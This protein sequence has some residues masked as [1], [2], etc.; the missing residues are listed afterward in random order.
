LPIADAAARREITGRVRPELSPDGRWVAYTVTDPRRLRTYGALGRDYTLVTETGAA[1]LVA[2]TDVWVANTTTGDARSVTGGVGGNW[3]AAW[4]PDGRSLAFY[5]DRDGAVRLWIWD[6]GTGTLRRVSDAVVRAYQTFERPQWFPDGQR[7]LVKLLPEGTTLDRLLDRGSESSPTAGAGDGSLVPTVTV[8]RAGRQ[9]GDSTAAGGAGSSRLGP[10][11][12]DGDLALVEARSGAV[13]RLV[14]NVSTVGYWISPRGSDV[15]YM[16]FG[17]DRGATAQSHYDLNV[18]SVADGTIRTLAPRIAQAFGVSVSWSPDG[19]R[20]AYTTALGTGIHSGPAPRGDCFVV[21]LTGGAP[22]N[23]TPGPHPTFGGDFGAPLW[24]PDGRSLLLIGGDTLWRAAADRDALVKVSSIPGRTLGQVIARDGD[25]RAWMP[26]GERVFLRTRDPATGREGFARVDLVT[27]RATQLV[28]EE[29]TYQNGVYGVDVLGSQMVYMAESV[30]EPGD[31]WIALPGKDFTR[32]RL[33]RLN[34]QLE[35]YEYGTSRL[36]EWLTDDGLPVRGALVLPAG[37]RPGRRYPVVVYV[38]GGSSLSREVFQF[39]QYIYGGNLTQVL[40]TRGYAVLLPDAPLSVG[41]PV[42]G[43]AKAV[44]PGVSKVV[45]LGIADPDRV[46]L[47]GGSYGGYS[48][49]ALVTQTTRFKAAVS[50]AGMSNLFTDYGH[51]LPRGGQVLTGWTERGYMR[52]GGSPWEVPFLYIENSPYFHLDRVETPVLLLHGEA[53]PAVPSYEGD[54]SFVA[55]RRLGKTV[56]YA[57]YAG[58]GHAWWGY[59]NTVDATQRTVAWFERYLTRS[60]AVA[61]APE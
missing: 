34:P 24:H 59:A 1:Y 10:R 35:G 58:E 15:A 26:D 50:I 45:E 29:R 56:E 55:L 32:R 7:L 54:E 19:T 43:L 40:A 23:V 14:R 8:F 38:Y 44:L 16:V 31:L 49:L 2:A 30:R 41:T 6:A 53:D 3:G 13:Q 25:G 17:R 48:T 47:M 36:V 52:T 12:Y 51:Q 20:L 60:P 28:E 61:R 22:R 11:L 27:G 33:T 46:G 37:Y 42:A 18:A 5:S 57:R 9:D 21:S 39:G 4:S